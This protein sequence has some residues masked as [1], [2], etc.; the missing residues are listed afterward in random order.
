MKNKINI[1]LVIFSFFFGALCM[2]FMILFTKKDCEV[3][4]KCDEVQLGEEVNFPIEQQNVF[5]LLYDYAS[6]IYEKEEYKQLNKNDDGMYYATLNDID[7]LN[8][9]VSS[10]GHCAQNYPLVY[11][12]V[13]N[14]IVDKYEGYPIQIVIKC[15]RE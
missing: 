7:K 4:K 1:L 10:L 6:K 13:N 5:D 3:C 14:T 11:F 9:D 2:F 15:T 12:D 8:Y